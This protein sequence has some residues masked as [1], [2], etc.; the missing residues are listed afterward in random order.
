[1]SLEDKMKF[2]GVSWLLEEGVVERFYLEDLEIGCYRPW[3][4]V[5]SER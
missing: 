4:N 2:I 3:F 5:D 1:M